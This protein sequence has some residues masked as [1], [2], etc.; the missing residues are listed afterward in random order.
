LQ[1]YQFHTLL[2]ESCIFNYSFALYPEE[3]QPSGCVNPNRLESMYL[4]LN[5]QDGLQAEDVAVIIFARS[6]NMLKFRDGVA[7]LSFS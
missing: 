4:V 3:P 1:P 2:P 7:G 6:L 5:I